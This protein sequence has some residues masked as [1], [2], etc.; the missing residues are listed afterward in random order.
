[1]SGGH[2]LCADRSGSGDKVVS[3]KPDEVEKTPHQ[4]ASL[5]ASPRGEAYNHNKRGKRYVSTLK[6]VKRIC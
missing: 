1:M 2:R 5:T 4:S 6:L 3:K